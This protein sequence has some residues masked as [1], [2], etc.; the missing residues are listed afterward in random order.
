MIAI[1]PRGQQ[2]AESV[3]RELYENPRLTEIGG[4][5]AEIEP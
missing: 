3:L 1:T 2:R 5:K 4:M